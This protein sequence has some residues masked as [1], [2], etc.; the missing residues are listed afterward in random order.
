MTEFFIDIGNTRIK[1]APN[2]QPF[3]LQFSEHA[4]LASVFSAINDAKPQTLLIAAG[5]SESAQAAKSNLIAYAATHH[6]PTDSVVVRPD[7]LPINYADPH[8]FGADRFLN[9]LAARA[10]YQK[11]FCVVSAGTAITLDFFTQTHIGG[12]ILLGLGS[13][14]SILSEKTGLADICKPRQLLGHD[15]AN[16][17]GAGIYVG[18]QNLIDRSIER[19]AAAEHTQFH[20][21]WTG[22]DA[23]ALFSTGELVPTLLFEGMARYHQRLGSVVTR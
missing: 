11:N 21:V 12:M 13:T 3:T 14:K 16:T 5:R 1:Y 18:L 9:L 17:V 4:R 19:I 7:W 15:T 8:Q 22:G 23:E 2:L 20:I 6:I 10:R